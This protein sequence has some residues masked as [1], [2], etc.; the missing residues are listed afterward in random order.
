VTFFGAAVEMSG[1]QIEAVRRLPYIRAIHLDRT[2]HASA[3]A[4]PIPR[5][6]P[7]TT[8]RLPSSGMTP[9]DD[10]AN[11]FAA[12]AAINDFARSVFPA[13]RAAASVLR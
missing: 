1:R 3:M 12:R 2:A 11:V 4:R 7:V 9:Q 6:A 5:L 10:G 8:T 13:S